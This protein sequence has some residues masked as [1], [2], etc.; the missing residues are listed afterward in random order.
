MSSSGEY[1]CTGRLMDSVNSYDEKNTMRAK[2]Q[3]E[4]SSS[5][6]TKLAT[7]PASPSAH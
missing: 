1:L 3:A 4:I 5:N 7:A 6:K 2:L